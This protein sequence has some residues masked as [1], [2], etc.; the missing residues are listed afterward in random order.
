M[1]DRQRMKLREGAKK[2][3]VSN[4][5]R[6]LLLNE[7]KLLLHKFVGFP[8]GSVGREAPPAKDGQWAKNWQRGLPVQ[9]EETVKTV[10]KSRPPPSFP[11]RA[12]P[13]LRDLGRME[14]VGSWL[15]RGAAPPSDLD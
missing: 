6:V 10:R 2:G 13:F 8:Q 7:Y 3:R 11:Q 1:I 5:R 4:G 12:F 9:K 14:E 15:S